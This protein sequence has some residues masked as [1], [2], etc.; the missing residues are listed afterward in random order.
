M[1][2][3][4][5][6]VGGSLLF[7]GLVQ[8]ESAKE[9][10]EKA[11]YL[12]ETKGDLEN[13]IEIY[14]RI[15]EEFP[16]ERK[17][18]AQALYQTGLCYEKLGLEEAQLAFQRII[19]IYP[20]QAEVVKRARDKLALLISARDVLKKGEK[21]FRVRKVWDDSGEPFSFGSPS[22]DGK[23]VSYVDWENF[24]NLGV[25][26]LEKGEN[27]L[28]TKNESWDT[29]EMALS[30]VFSP[31][32][33]QI[34]YCWQNKEGIGELRVINRDGSQP[35]I[36]YG[37]KEKGW[38]WPAAWSLDGKHIL[39]FLHTQGKPNTIAF[40]SITDG[41]IREVKTLAPC[42]PSP[43]IRMSLSPDGRYIAYNYLQQ[44]E[45][46]EHDIF[47]LSTDGS[48]HSPL[49][50]HP[51]DD[52]VIGW[53][54][55]SK[56]VIFKSD[57]TGSPGLW[58]IQVAEGNA[59][60]T[61]QLLRTEM[62]N[63]GVLGMAQD[64]SL[65]Y[66]LRSGWSDVFTATVDPATGDIK[67]QPV[68][69]IQQFEG[70]NSAPDCS[71]DGEYLVCRSSRKDL[72]A[73]LLILSI[74]TG[75]VREL[76]PKRGISLNFH[77]LRWSPDG[78]SF[79]GV[80]SYKGKYGYLFAIDSQ[81]GDVE[82]V[83]EPDENKGVIHRSDWSPDSN[84]IFFYRMSREA[85]T[86]IRRDLK[87]GV[88]KEIY[89]P[90][91]GNVYALTL[92]S[93]GQQLA[94]SSDNKLMVLSVT[95]GEPKELT[96]VKNLST[97]AWTRDSKYIF[98][99]LTRDKGDKVDLWRIPAEGGEPQRLE[100]AMTRLMHLRTHPDGER[101]VFTAQSRSP[102]AEIWV[103]ENFLPSEKKKK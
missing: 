6:L 45:S 44:E 83:A 51:V 52:T 31:D 64:G 19:D 37:D 1:M 10:F 86:I 84:A 2:A 48:H 71:P 78:K 80:G 82:I 14:K 22:P 58:L 72:D 4:F 53:T 33:S 96:P 12:E 103:I 35:R 74:S 3:L 26:D 60:G 70:F 79:L 30:S 28:L 98:F 34:A 77:Y 54:L 17:T 49:I 81:T 94:F 16:D 99:G 102:K 68:K 73:A 85:Y 76:V 38:P 25:R 100:L 9:L 5:L 24:G 75:E 7:S 65:F 91:K 15:V 97:I 43:L 41:F 88:E 23:Y 40:I 29:G 62:G 89:R 42:P 11:L 92:S 56:G 8:K 93:D 69:I 59:E 20:E 39:T 57:R 63:F 27:R 61:P 87:T 50:E 46:R 90:P 66:N 95:G 101:I 32:G 21:K 18:A 67:S 36:L 47:L 13:A 55:D